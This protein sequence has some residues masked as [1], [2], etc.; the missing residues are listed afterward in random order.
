MPWVSLLFPL[1]PRDLLALQTREALGSELTGTV[2]PPGDLAASR[3]E[4][5]EEGKAKGILIFLSFPSPSDTPLS[6]TQ[7]S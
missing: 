7:K 4:R 1:P 5:K 6:A 3:W 2:P